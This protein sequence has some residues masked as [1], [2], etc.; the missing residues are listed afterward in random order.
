MILFSSEIFVDFLLWL[1][2]LLVTLLTLIVFN[3]ESIIF[4]K[5]KVIVNQGK[6]CHCR[7]ECLEHYSETNKNMFI[8]INE[9][10]VKIRT[11]HFA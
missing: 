11:S 1:H 7:E 6:S 3:L 4:M 10:D 8:N 2:H 5:G 9:V